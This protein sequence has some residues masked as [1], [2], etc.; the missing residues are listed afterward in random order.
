MS[1]HMKQKVLS[2]KDKSSIQDSMS[3]VRIFS[4]VVPNKA[5]CSFAA[6]EPTRFKGVLFFV[7]RSL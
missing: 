7:C 5:A 4:I 2:I 6:F 1:L 3:K